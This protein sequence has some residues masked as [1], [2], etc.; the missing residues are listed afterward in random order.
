MSI[1]SYSEWPRCFFCFGRNCLVPT[2][3]YRELFSEIIINLEYSNPIDNWR[4]IDRIL[5]TSFLVNLQKLPR[6]FHLVFILPVA[7]QNWFFSWFGFI[8][9]LKLK[10]L[11]KAYSYGF[12]K[13]KLAP[14][15]LKSIKSFKYYSAFGEYHWTNMEITARYSPFSFHLLLRHK[16][17]M[18]P[19]WNY[20]IELEMPM[21]KFFNFNL[22]YVLMKRGTSLFFFFYWKQIW[23]N[24]F[25]F[26]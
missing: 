23:I 14:T 3:H 13:L 18:I 1:R 17:Y 2:L 22:Y 15:E 6:P 16:P 24:C 21:L 9:H 25:K 5:Q 4:H 7:K 8:E 19:I 26:V 10:L 20:L 11:H 12:C